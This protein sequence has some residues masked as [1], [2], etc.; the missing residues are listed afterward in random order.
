MI[1]IENV[2]HRFTSE[3]R[4]ETVA[5]QDVNLTINKNEFIT[6][7]GPS[8][9]GKTTLM[10]AVG[11]LV[12]PTEGTVAIDGQRVTGPHQQSAIVFQNFALLPWETVIN[13]V[14]FGLELKGISKS[15]RLERAKSYIDKVGLAGFEDKYPRELS[16]GMQQRV[17]LARALSVQTPILLMDEPF[18]ALDQQ[19]RRYMQEE[20]LDIWQQDQRTVIFVT[21]DMEE[22]VLLGDRVVLMSARPGK[23]EEVIDVNL[24][25]PRNAEAAEHSPELLEVKDY[26]W[27]RLR[28][29]HQQVPA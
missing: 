6:I 12:V 10:R 19:T 29:M 24:P 11:G 21:H 23:I 20:L 9:C 26:L 17:G 3:R 28:D 4:G 25:R 27:R 16:G 8:G 13:N 14:A 18:G 5:L 2:G 7:I 1:T 15:E 22:A